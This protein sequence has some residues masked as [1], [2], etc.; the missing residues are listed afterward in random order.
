VANSSQVT[1][2]SRRN[3][4][5]ICGTGAIAPFASDFYGGIVAVTSEV[6]TSVYGRGLEAMVMLLPA[7]LFSTRKMVNAG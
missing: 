4:P 6:L 3:S 1:G 5:E 7:F 2:E